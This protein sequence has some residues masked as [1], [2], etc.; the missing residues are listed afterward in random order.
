LD[1]Q[2]ID[3]L[4]KY[5]NKEAPRYLDLAININIFLLILFFPFRYLIIGLKWSIAQVKNKN[6]FV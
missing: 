3:N 2:E 4:E 1:K 6:S 5:I